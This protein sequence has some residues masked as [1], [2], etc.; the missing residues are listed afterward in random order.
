MSLFFF[1]HFHS[2]NILDVSG[3]FPRSF[4]LFS[5]IRSCSFPPHTRFGSFTSFVRCIITHSNHI[6]HFDYLILTWW[7]YKIQATLHKRANRAIYLRVQHIIR[8]FERC[9]R[10]QCFDCNHHHYNITISLLL[11]WQQCTKTNKLSVIHCFH[12]IISNLLMVKTRER[13]INFPDFRIFIRFSLNICTFILCWLFL[14]F[15][16]SAFFFISERFMQCF[17]HSFFRKALH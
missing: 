10:E 13:K 6:N 9:L 11:L 2:T 15:C 5:S 12:W 4:I 8:L 17:T 16:F 7:L 1:I 14:P 3:V